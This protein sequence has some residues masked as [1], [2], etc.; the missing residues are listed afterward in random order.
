MKCVSFLLKQAKALIVLSALGFFSCTTVRVP[1]YEISE[2]ASPAKS[3]ICIVQISD[4]HSNTFGKGEQKLLRK[5]QAASPDLIMLTGDIFEF[6]RKDAKA[7]ENVRLLLEGIQNLAPFYYVSGNHEY[8]AYHNDEYSYLIEEYGGV[9]LNDTVA[10]ATTEKGSIIVAGV[11][12]PHADIDFKARLK[13]KDDKIAY[14]ARLAR[15]A[16]AAS[17][18]KAA[19]PEALYSVLLAHRPEYI[20]DYL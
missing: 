19:H 4:F 16:K 18:L 2:D 20:S 9:V 14:R 12:D 1:E 13:N 8:K 11:S 15:T 17:S 10:L 6:T 7:I 5:I 3:R